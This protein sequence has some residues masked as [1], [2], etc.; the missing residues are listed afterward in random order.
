MISNSLINSLIILK[1]SDS[2]KILTEHNVFTAEKWVVRVPFLQPPHKLVKNITEGK[3]GKK[4]WRK[5]WNIG[6]EKEEKQRR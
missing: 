1:C 5:E 4:W 2:R 6:K 3:T